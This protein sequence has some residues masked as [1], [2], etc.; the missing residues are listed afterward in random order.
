M[1]NKDEQE[2][3][4]STGGIGGLVQKVS[5]AVNNFNERL[6]RGEGNQIWQEVSDTLSSWKDKAQENREARENRT[7]VTEEQVQAFQDKVAD[8][9][10]NGYDTL[11][12]VR[13]D[14]QA[15]SDLIKE[16]VAKTGTLD[17]KSS[18]YEKFRDIAESAGENSPKEIKRKNKTFTR[19]NRAWADT[20]GT[21][22]SK[23]NAVDE[24]GT[25][26][27]KG[28][29]DESG[30]FVSGLAEWAEDNE[31]R[32]N[33]EI[34]A[35][36]DTIENSKFLTEDE[37][38]SRQQEL[39]N[40][41]YDCG[42]LEEYSQ[43]VIDDFKAEYDQKYFSSEEE[44]AAWD[45]E[46]ARLEN[47]QKV[48]S[49]WKDQAKGL[50]DKWSGVNEIYSYH[51]DDK[52][53]DA[54][55]FINDPAYF[56]SPEYGGDTVEN[57]NKKLAR[58][59][60]AIALEE[61]KDR[62][63][64]N[65][66]LTT[67]KDEYEQ[68]KKNIELAKEREK[69][70]KQ[71]IEDVNDDILIG[72]KYLFY[73]PE[74]LKE[75]E[76][77]LSVLQSNSSLSEAERTQVDK[78]LAYVQKHIESNQKQA[79]K[80]EW[81]GKTDTEIK[82]EI[83]RLIKGPETTTKPSIK[84]SGRSVEE[85]QAEIDKLE[86]QFGSLNPLKD[87]EKWDSIQDQIDVLTAEKATVSQKPAA[88]EEIPKYERTAEE[89]LKLQAL[90][91]ILED[92]ALD[93]VDNQKSEL[94]NVYDQ[95][96]KQYGESGA[97]V[98]MEE[99]SA[100]TREATAAYNA[101]IEE[102]VTPWKEAEAAY[103]MGE[104][105]AYPKG[106]KY[107][108]IRKELKAAG[109]GETDT[110]KALEYIRGKMVDLS[111]NSK[112]A[113]EYYKAVVASE[114]ATRIWD[115]TLKERSD[116]NTKV[117][118]GQEKLDAI[119]GVEGLRKLYQG[120]VD[121]LA[122]GL[123]I[124]KEDAK[125]LH[126]MLGTLGVDEGM[127]TPSTT[128]LDSNNSW[129][130]TLRNF[131]TSNIAGEDRPDVFS[132]DEYN[133]FLYLFSDDVIHSAEYALEKNSA[134]NAA[135]EA[136]LK[137]KALNV[138][139][140]DKEKHPGSFAFFAVIDPVA[141]AV[142]NMTGIV[143][144]VETRSQ[145]KNLGHDVA[146]GMPSLSEWASVINE[147]NTSIIGQGEYGFIKPD[148]VEF[149]YNAY[150]S[151]IQSR[152]N[153]AAVTKMAGGLGFVRNGSPV[154]F[155]KNAFELASGA[156]SDVAFFGSASMETYREL[157]E[158]GID[159][160]R[161][162]NVGT[163]A[164]VFEAAFEHISLDKIIHEKD[165]FHIKN[166]GEALGEVMVHNAVEG[167]EE[168]CTE[169]ANKVY[170][171]IVL[172]EDSTFWRN[173][174]KLR[175]EGLTKAEAIKKEYLNEA[176]EILLA[177]AAGFVSSVVPAS[178]STF[179]AYARSRNDIKDT[180]KI[181]G[182]EINKSASNSEGETLAQRLGTFL[183]NYEFYTAE[184]VTPNQAQKK[185]IN[186]LKEI[187]TKAAE[188]KA[189]DTEIAQMIVLA[190][191]YD[192]KLY[193]D[194]VMD[195]MD[196]FLAISPGS[197]G[198]AVIN[199]LS[200]I[201]GEE[202]ASNFL[203]AFYA[204]PDAYVEDEFKQGLR[205]ALG[206]SE[207]TPE[208]AEQV[209]ALIGYI[210]TGNSTYD[211]ETLRK[212]IQTIVKDDKT[213]NYILQF[214]GNQISKYSQGNKRVFEFQKENDPSATA[215]FAAVTDRSAITGDFE[216]SLINVW[217]GVKEAVGYAAIH[218][219]ARES[220]KETLA[221]FL[222]SLGSVSKTQMAK[223][224]DDGDFFVAKGPDGK[225][226]IFT[227]EFFIQQHKKGVDPLTGKPSAFQNLVD[228]D[229]KLNA[230]FDG[231]LR[232]TIG[233]GG[234]ADMARY[235]LRTGEEKTAEQTKMLKDQLQDI[236][237]VPDANLAILRNEIRDIDRQ[238]SDLYTQAE[239][240]KASNEPLPDQHEDA[241]K[242]LEARKAK[243]EADLKIIQER[244]KVRS[245]GRI[246]T[247]DSG[248]SGRNA[249]AN[250]RGNAGG[251]P[252]RTGSTGQSSGTV[253]A[254]VGRDPGSGSGS[255]LR[256]EV[257][258]KDGDT[259][260]A[261]MDNGSV[262]YDS[263]DPKANKDNLTTAEQDVLQMAKDAGVDRLI[264]VDADQ[265]YG[266]GN[267]AAGYYVIIGGK[268]TI[269]VNSNRG[270]VNGYHE[271]MH[272]CLDSYTKEEKRAILDQFIVGL[273]GSKEEFKSFIN[274]Y[275]NETHQKVYASLYTAFK[276]GN[277]APY[278]YALYEEILCDLWKGLNRYHISNEQFSPLQQRAYAFVVENQIIEHA[279]DQ[280]KQ[281]KSTKKE[282]PKKAPETHGGI[283]R[284]ETPK[285]QEAPKARSADEQKAEEFF[286][287]LV[288]QSDDFDL[289]PF[290]SAA[291]DDLLQYISGLDRAG[292]AEKQVIAAVKREVERRQGEDQRVEEEKNRPLDTSFGEARLAQV[293]ETV[294][295]LS[296]SELAGMMREMA[297]LLGRISK[298][299]PD[300]IILEPVTNILINEYRHRLAQRGSESSETE[301]GTVTSDQPTDDLPK[302]K[303]KSRSKKTQQSATQSTEQP[304][305]TEEQPVAEQPPESTGNPV[306]D[307]INSLT[308][309]IAEYD[310]MIAENTADRDKQMK[311]AADP[312]MRAIIKGEANKLI[313]LLKDERA[314]LQKRL[315]ALKK[316]LR[317]ETAKN[318]KDK[319]RTEL[320]NN[321]EKGS[322]KTP[323]PQ[324]ETH[325]DN[326]TQASVGK[327]N[328]NAFQYDNPEVK[329]FFKRAAD[330]LMRDLIYMQSSRRTEYGKGTVYGSTNR[331]LEKV[332]E[333]FGSVDKAI[334][335][336]EAIIT[337]RG[338]ENYAG[339]K[340]IEL[341]L[342]EMLSDGYTAIS[343]E[344]ESIESSAEYMTL[345]GTLQGGTPFDARQRAIEL[346]LA[347]DFE[348]ELTEED[349]GKIVDANKERTGYYDP[350]TRDGQAEQETAGVEDTEEELQ[351]AIDKNRDEWISLMA[352]TTNGSRYHHYSDGWYDGYT[353]E[354]VEEETVRA[355]EQR[356]QELESQYE[357]LA[358]RM[359]RIVSSDD[360]DTIY[361]PDNGQPITRR[362][363]VDRAMQGLDPFDGVVPAPV[364]TR[365]EANEEF[366]TWIREQ[367]EATESGLY[368][369]DDSYTPETSDIYNKFSVESLANGTGFETLYQITGSNK[370]TTLEDWIT[371]NQRE[372][373]E[374]TRDSLQNDFSQLVE[375]GAA[376]VIGVARRDPNGELLKVELDEITSGAMK[377]SPL[378]QM[379]TYAKEF[380]RISEEEANRQYGFLADLVKLLY[381]YDDTDFVWRVV[382]SEMFAA[383][384]NNSDPQYGKTI[385]F[386][387]I[388]KKTQATIDAIS[389]TMKLLGTGLSKEEI[390]FV[391]KMVG[392]AGESTPCPVCYVFSR[393]MGL[394]SVLDNIKRYQD[395]YGDRNPN[396]QEEALK[397]VREVQDRALS[398]TKG[399]S[400]GKAVNAAQAD[401]LKKLKAA[402][403]NFQNYPLAQLGSKDKK[404]NRSLTDEN[405]KAVTQ[406]YWADQISTLAADY[407][408]FDAYKWAIKTRLINAELLVKNSEDIAAKLRK[409]Y[410][411]KGDTVEA[412]LDNALQ[413]TNTTDAF[414]DLVNELSDNIADLSLVEPERLN[415]LKRKYALKKSQS[416][417][418]G[419][420]TKLT[421]SGQ[422]TTEAQRR[423]EENVAEYKEL[424]E[425]LGTDDYVFRKGYKDVPDDILFDLNKGEQFARYY[426]ETWTYRTT[427]GSGLGKAIMPYSDARVGEI[428]QGVALGDV[429]GVKIGKDQNAFL[430][431]LDPRKKNEA[432]KILATARK[433][434]AAQ[435]LIGGMRF[436]STSDFRYEYASD[437]LMAFFE[438]QAMGANVQLY[439]KVLEAVDFFANV[440][441][442]VNLSVMPR[443]KGIGV[444][445][446][447]PRDW[448][449]NYDRYYALEDG[450]YV[451]LRKGKSVPDFEPG[452]YHAIL[453]SDVTGVNGGAA[454]EYVQKY[455]NVQ[456]IMVGISADH[457]NACL[458]SDDITFI[459][460]FHGSGN[461]TAD[462]QQLMQLLGETI[463][464]KNITD[465]TDYQ[466]DAQRETKNDARDLRH[467]IVSG[468]LLTTDGQIILTAEEANILESHELLRDL[469][470]RFYLDAT[471]KNG[472]ID[473]GLSKENREKVSVI[474]TNS[475]GSHVKLDTPDFG[476]VNDKAFAKKYYLDGR[477]ECYGN[478]L[479]GAAA[480]QI[481]PYEYWD[482]SLK[483][484]EAKGNGDAFQAYAKSLGLVPRFSGFAK[485]KDYKAELDFTKNDNY[486]KL[487]ID[488][489][490]Y[491]N[492]GNYR[493]QR[494]INL[495]EVDVGGSDRFDFTTLNPVY[496]EVN[497]GSG[498]EFANRVNPKAAG[499]DNSVISKINDPRKT[500]ALA[501]I[502]A[503]AIRETRALSDKNY[504]HMFSNNEDIQQAMENEDYLTAARMLRENPTAVFNEQ[505]GELEVIAEDPT[506]ETFLD[507]Y[508]TDGKLSVD[509][510]DPD[511][512]AWLNKLYED[513]DVVFTYK[514]YLEYKDEDGVYLIAPMAG[515]QKDEKGNN[516][517]SHKLRPMQWEKSI[518]NPNSKN[519]KK[520]KKG[521]WVYV[522]EK[523]DVKS[524]VDATYNPYQ[525]SGDLAINDQFAIAY[526]RP[527]L[528]TYI[529]A[530]PKS[531]LTSGYH[532]GVTDPEAAKRSDGEIVTAKDPVGVLDWKT[533]PF[534]SQLQNSKRHTYLSRWLMPIQRVSDEEVARQ[535]KEIIDREPAGLGVPFNVVPQNVRNILEDMG[536]PIDITG[537]GIREDLYRTYLRD[538]NEQRRQEG[539]EPYPYS[540]IERT[541]QEKE[542]IK[543]QRKAEAKRMREERGEEWA[544]YKVGDINKAP[545]EKFSVD[546]ED[547]EGFGNWLNSYSSNETISHTA[548]ESSFASFPEL[549]FFKKMVDANW[550]NSGST[551]AVE[552]EFQEF[553]SKLDDYS[554]EKLFKSFAN[555]VEGSRVDW[556]RY[557]NTPD[558]T[559]DKFEKKLRSI[560]EKDL[561]KKGYSSL[562]KEQLDEYRPDYVAA[563]QQMYDKDDKGN[564]IGDDPWHK[565]HQALYDLFTKHPEL[566]YLKRLGYAA[567]TGEKNQIRAE[568]E[569]LL[570]GINDRDA[571]WQL[572][573]YSIYPSMG[574]WNGGSRV[575]G[576]YEKLKK[577]KRLFSNIIEK[578]RDQ[579]LVEAG[580]S[581]NVK[582]EARDYTLQEVIDMF[583]QLNRDEQL[584]PLAEKVFKVTKDLGL[585]IRGAQ[586]KA[587]RTS[588]VGGHQLGSVVEYNINR[589]ND[590]GITDQVKATILLHELIHGCT[591]YALRDY[592]GDF[593]NLQLTE[594]M[595]EAVRQIMKVYYAVRADSNL[596][597]MYG[598][599]S[600]AEMLSELANP[601]FREALEKK[602]LVQRII[603][604]IK[605]FFGIDTKNVLDAA[606]VGL[607]YLLDNFNYD[608]YLDWVKYS[609]RYIDRN[610]EVTQR[611]KDSV[612]A[613]QQSLHPG[614]V[615]LS[616][617]HWVSQEYA[618]QD[619]YGDWQLKS[620]YILQTEN[621]VAQV[622]EYNPITGEVT[623]A[624]S[625]DNDSQQSGFMTGAIDDNSNYT[626]EGFFNSLGEEVTVGKFSADDRILSVTYFAGAGT[627]DYALRD[628]LFHLYAVEYD[629][630]IRDMFLK[631][632]GNAIMVT[633]ADVNE[634]VPG[635][636]I[637][638]HV[639]YFHASPVCTNFSIANNK[640]GETERDRQFARS[641]AK[642]I[643][644]Y[645]PD[646]FTL[647]NVKGYVGS[648]SLQIVLDTLD[649][650][651]YTHDG[652][653]GNI[654]RASDYG[655]ATIRDRL[656]VRAVRNGDLPPK[657]IEVGP[658]TWWA[659]VEDIINTL[660]VMDESGLTESRRNRLRNMGID[661]N[662]L[663]Q[664]LLLLS[665]T[666]GKEIQYAYADQ[667]SPTLMTD[668]SEARIILTDG[669]ILK[670]TPRVFARIQG[671]DDEF[672]FPT[673]KRNPEKIHQTNAFKI[674]GNGIPTQLTRAIVNPLLDTIE[675]KNKQK[676][677]DQYLGAIERGDMDTARALFNR[678]VLGRN[679]GAVTPFL[680]TSKY[681]DN[682]GH[683]SAVAHGIKLKNAKYLNMAADE[684]VSQV[685]DDAVLIP[686]P[687]RHGY[688]SDTLE[689]AQAI[690]DRY[691]ETHETQIEVLDILKGNDRPSQYETKRATGKSLNLDTFGM[692]LDG[693]IP[694]GKFPVLIDNVVA[695]GTTATSA[696]KAVGGGMTLAFAYGDRSKPV[697]GLKLADPVTY[698]DN[699]NPIPLSERFNPDNPDIR[700]STD[701]EPEM[702]LNFRDP[703]GELLERVF[704]GEKIYETRPYTDKRG[705]GQIKSAW[706]NK[707]MGI[708]QTGAGRAKVVGQWELGDGELRDSQ[709]LLDHARELGNDGTEFEAHPGE[710]KWIYPIK[711]AE[712]VEPRD[713][714]SWGPQARSIK[715]SVDIDPA[716]VFDSFGYE[717]ELD[718]YSPV[719]TLSDL[720][721]NL[722]Y[723]SDGNTA[724][725][726]TETGETVV[727]Q[728][729]GED[730]PE[731][732][733]INNLE[734]TN[735]A[736][737]NNATAEPYIIPPANRY[738]NDG[739]NLDQPNAGLRRGTQEVLT[740]NQEGT[741]RS[742]RS[743][744]ELYAESVPQSEET[745]GIRY[746][747]E[748]ESPGA[749]YS[750]M[751]D[752]DSDTFVN[753]NGETVATDDMYPIGSFT[754]EIFKALKSGDQSLKN[755]EDLINKLLDRRFN[756]YE[757]D[758]NT[759]QR[760]IQINDA[761]TPEQR[762]AMLKAMEKLVKKHGKMRSAKEDM[763]QDLHFAV[764]R[765]Q[766]DTIDDPNHKGKKITRKEFVK[767]A[768]EGKDPFTGEDS[769]KT[770]TEKEA[771]KLFD[772]QGTVIMKFTQTV[773]RNSDKEWLTDEAVRMALTDE[774][775]SYTPMANDEAIRRAQ[776]R[777]DRA[778]SYE[779]ALAEWDGIVHSERTPK[780][781]DVAF[782]ELLL[783][784]ATE[785]GL[786][787]DTVKLVSDLTL[788][789]HTTGQTLQAFRILKKMTPRGQLYY[790]QSVV[791]D[792][793][794]R[795]DSRIKSGKMGTVTLN[796]SLVELLLSSSTREELDTAVDLIKKDLA[797][798][799]PAT[800][801]DQWN[802]W[803][804]LAMLGNPRTHFRNIF[805]NGAFMPAVFVKDMIARG[806]EKKY[807]DP[808]LRMRI[809]GA[810]L[811]QNS[812][813]RQRAEQ[814]FQVMRKIIA[815]EAGG[816]KYSDIQ[817][818]L[819]QRDVFPF[820]W[821]NDL[822]RFNGG[823][824]SA[825]DLWFMHKYY[826]RAFAE[827]LQA[828]GIKE[829]D[830]QSFDSN[831]DGRKTLNEIRNWAMEEAQRNTYHDANKLA[832][833][834]NQM[835]RSSPTAYVVLEGLVPFTKTPAN[836]LKRGIE[837]SPIGL[838]SSYIQLG[839]DL[840]SGDYSTSQCI[841]RLA[842]GWT[843]TMLMVAGFILSKMGVLRGGGPDDK[844]E[845]AF[846]TLQGHQPW[847][848]EIGGFSYTLDW[849]APTALP[850]FV[851]NAIYSML[852]GDHVDITD[853]D[854]WMALA[855]I[856]DPLLSLSMLDGIENTL[857]AVSNANN[858]SKL[859]VLGISMFGSYLAQGM[860][861]ILGQAA[862]I[863]D[864]NRRKTFVPEGAKSS[865]LKQWVQ[866]S[867]QAK[868]P[869]P[870]GL[871]G[872]NIP[873]TEDDKK[874]YV[875]M[876]GRT[877]GADTFGEVLWKIAENVISPGYHKWINETPV[878]AELQRLYEATQDKS[879]LPSYVDKSIGPQSQGK[880]D[881]GNEIIIDGKKL[882]ADEMT[883]YEMTVGQNRYQLLSDIFASQAYQ[884]ATDTE[885]K[886][887]VSDA[888]AYAKSLGEKAVIDGREHDY[889]W[890][891]LADKI[892]ASDYILI[893]QE[894][895]NNKSN[896][897]IFSWLVNNPNLNENQVAT[898][899][900]DKFN[901]PDNVE[902]VSSSGF[903]YEL[904]GS[905]EDIIK[906]INAQII[907]DGLRKLYSSEEYQNAPDKDM[908]L[909]QF[910]EESRAETIKLYGEM[911]DQTDRV[912]YVGK[913]ASIGAESFNKVLDLTTADVKG[914]Y[915]SD[916]EAQ[917]SWLGYKYK[918]DTSIN[919]PL[920]EGYSIELDKTQRS[921][922]ESRFRDRWNDAYDELVHSEK[923]QNAPSREYQE[924]MIA[925]RFN[926]VSTEVENEYAAELYQAGGYSETFG[927]PGSFAWSK[928]YEIAD[929]EL[930]TPQEQAE[931]LAGKYS[932]GSSIDDP[933]QAAYEINLTTEDKN[934]LKKEFTSAYVP[935]YVKMVNSAEFK[936][937]DPT[938]QE[939]KK[940]E[941]RKDV[942]K[943]VQEAYAR[944]L[945]ADGYASVAYDDKA[946]LANKYE[947][948][949]SND[950]SNKE[951]IE[952]IKDSYVG[953]TIANAE[954]RGYRKQL[955]D[956]WMDNPANT[957][958]YLEQNTADS[959]KKMRDAADKY[960]GKLTKQKYGNVKNYSDIEDFDLYDVYYTTNNP[961]NGTPPVK[962]NEPT[963]SKTDSGALLR[964]GN[965]DLNARPI[966]RNSDGSYSTVD[967]ATWEVD[968]KYVNVPTVIYVED[969]TIDGEYISGDW[970][971]VD[972]DKALEHYFETGEHLGIYSDEKSAVRAAE[973]LHEDQAK[974]YDPIANF[975]SNLIRH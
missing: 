565:S 486:W 543:K 727:I 578:R 534:G 541:D 294:S 303:K 126:K 538:V 200:A 885:K 72:R 899:I 429:K 963:T 459:I 398:Y 905:D 856:A 697:P 431:L 189:S 348:Q 54:D 663:K 378:G 116:Y 966:V 63:G 959:Y 56:A 204:N 391:Y 41:Y 480:N 61:E 242:N 313:Q 298:D 277:T 572:S 738:G 408:K 498:S 401:I 94:K 835:K 592:D 451:K 681:S 36:N 838:V 12:A 798:Q 169:T 616:T 175:E 496:G 577:A 891:N 564:L 81:S 139:Q 40:L 433:K 3:S 432:E 930:S 88:P 922:L 187:A 908:M 331:F 953:G 338:G 405:G 923:F 281:S 60:K 509:V 532:Y 944:K 184:G 165:V 875:D 554:K 30:N 26:H 560:L 213:K 580:D 815:G 343:P 603:D 49:G 65:S 180:V 422:D 749:R 367:Y 158:R 492:Q 269:V 369:V 22:G 136:R 799:I 912:K 846:E 217:S 929:R 74:K 164:G 264:F 950:L 47:N 694:E 105:Y 611:A 701:T 207:Y 79:I 501:Q 23:R 850:L 376:R 150:S 575:S 753:E 527:N 871:F 935:R 972:A 847:S 236:L 733:Y 913:A 845:E 717:V 948:L 248:T 246:Q 482:K 960:A 606:S 268:K 145:I 761:Y 490:M 113:Q 463:D 314:E 814:D 596:T 542:A 900:A 924:D 720:S 153:A 350:D 234:L 895:E 144:Y 423:V 134:K 284:A 196:A 709:W 434:M 502:S 834:L 884:E 516:Q 372:N 382:G 368:S 357:D 245:N 621:G 250:E 675:A 831:P 31:A 706:L 651:G 601:D 729:I 417:L 301:E 910:Y 397:L 45:A 337:D 310:R 747:A 1:P 227:R 852:K 748:E 643:R 360:S 266:N 285:V 255:T 499:K 426:P 832:S 462:I 109:I 493:A 112:E 943:S 394:G 390:K 862:R 151:M 212:T 561:D 450:R 579:I 682:Y 632:N 730:S 918:A 680:Y 559:L 424:I 546:E 185:E 866:S 769:D 712:R 645:T 190:N 15:V 178:A 775:M 50:Y 586:G 98:W 540:F 231:Q 305:T 103:L 915:R 562:T 547:V 128:E 783:K 473:V 253:Q 181:L 604:A 881:D 623:P 566:D 467:K 879:V 334:E 926:Q 448:D 120:G 354:K 415:K 810:D 356:L 38:Q 742:G 328:V 102:N 793:N 474:R 97:Q 750:T 299:N 598:A 160:A 622:Y 811:S 861:T 156:F 92:R 29:T 191:R 238:L 384:K 771:N 518:G 782:G 933:D 75:E 898:L 77:R 457:I 568:F 321:I 896:E 124:S 928:A 967:T 785:Q 308:Q 889:E 504:G 377:N 648:D 791:D 809:A 528:V 537:T 162:W 389:K 805:G 406:D 300:R 639:P 211:E 419:V 172:G 752:S 143:D 131:V 797:E 497:F 723:S 249:D 902:S 828:R 667:P 260:V 642:A 839:R 404:I 345:K 347:G 64:T 5:D 71:Q 425:A 365:E 931:W 154:I 973:Q 353:G 841:D 957:A 533:G 883:K 674:V 106:G 177:G 888:Y 9:R 267:R 351:A 964:P 252:Y 746:S 222:K 909:K 548:F 20:E 927:K 687:G 278:Y 192:T 202:D 364:M 251:I 836:I 149:C 732:R 226:H 82:A 696:Q 819:G 947:Y 476:K 265:L 11:E 230:E 673:Q 399:R 383:I 654:Y 860:P 940:E 676:I 127:F 665:G 465:F 585:T 19:N 99:S 529:C 442:D 6:E 865:A 324:P 517:L 140:Y 630:D 224:R 55:T 869:D 336:C 318:N 188:G 176:K 119:G 618:E 906:E 744:G 355:F 392:E 420:V 882:T 290:V 416:G 13:V 519:I 453:Y 510:T 721:N 428:V 27:W 221:N 774:S 859:G 329:P 678:Y 93:S 80:E 325:I 872:G 297:D 759:V 155:D 179:S 458:D 874:L 259:A 393:W 218:K 91:S 141:T 767:R 768:T 513:G 664:P 864:T 624:G 968:G 73:S 304:T 893:R 215:W 920:H 703:T 691:N 186:T 400:F 512:L 787:N 78:D 901:P 240:A 316:Q 468:K 195:N 198:K 955:F 375:S 807:V 111:T 679:I 868:I 907:Q 478:F 655:A 521:N 439:T 293:R 936:A 237:S 117:A 233:A 858:T 620:G 201:Y 115:S 672:Q 323:N 853:A 817:D 650:M 479:S 702:G 956:Q 8:Y 641:I 937:L 327:S 387:T 130:N 595:R 904:N 495:S 107:D 210:V 359:S 326:R 166:F 549:D 755:V 610:P 886:K 352:T 522:L 511:E 827:A 806:L 590:L 563:I 822:A 121:K 636:I 821:L 247:H 719:V 556:S 288:R 276:N 87:T 671:L 658:T 24:N 715:F 794:K 342:D 503:N 877:E 870:L 593:R 878:D 67:Y 280:A 740:Q 89:E 666:K 970:V 754:R 971:H 37:V 312:N 225:D 567:T 272:Y 262:V 758:Y 335:A 86:K 370:T 83:D 309:E 688:A 346:V 818:I 880:D 609:N 558:K 491:D 829:E 402:E 662:N 472:R 766:G 692:Y 412:V 633:D 373:E 718:D 921:R 456:M 279:A 974:Q 229:D 551:R 699:G 840:R 292:D 848:I 589:F 275:N 315:A 58:L 167:V 232:A 600:A 287:F 257:I 104:F 194:F 574:V 28:H 932:P 161:A 739:Y 711:W 57:L 803:R 483:Q 813:Y 722:Y 101:F 263:A 594:D 614:E 469:F 464:R 919:N 599:K 612:S 530:I 736:N 581:S 652:Y 183:G 857:S 668:G 781:V 34:N 17:S 941:L 514:S 206:D 619:S 135:F 291:P 713:V 646:V 954:A 778:G 649:D 488:R 133:N 436:Q 557:Y 494:Q 142:M 873:G 863:L 820:K 544:N 125:E 62:W 734:A 640:H 95:Y 59:D 68:T 949:A 273:F 705:N 108:E 152:I 344:T 193:N 942:A 582:L 289:D 588:K 452:K 148:V 485:G 631:N 258:L 934:Q 524:P 385:D 710:S 174:T 363:F 489:K 216:D 118:Q 962:I 157:R 322:K 608:A 677:D 427:R 506:Q 470:R 46:L 447:K 626:I 844:K 890:M 536:V 271:A 296:D 693:Q 52:L 182:S 484:S 114:T 460:P 569:Q 945:K 760:M 449:T 413:S 51:D 946:N 638:G 851:G 830:V 283:P 349:A 10:Q 475:D 381:S 395:M 823:R 894:Y 270:S 570:S 756:I 197:V 961:I 796:Q 685:P 925:R 163:A 205:A 317:K 306:Q 208:Y 535:Y 786:I 726:Q 656:F 591:Q 777:F 657:P 802:A 887:I 625:K 444:L 523:S 743:D 555:Y 138:T 669:T 825:E 261:S 396:G 695:S 661:I 7:P 653:E 917:S 975:W 958:P 670:V 32:I 784:S 684:M 454:K 199:T 704:N 741:L 812:A 371:A 952:I 635:T 33:S 302:P 708:I 700:Y 319:R 951:K 435:N 339:P 35:Y 969:E 707:P 500:D 235:N 689:L 43:K 487:L 757:E 605:K 965:I 430:D 341:F 842:A 69:D 100:K 18:I 531:E 833:L 615:K 4:T 602:N 411:I 515:L 477:N 716:A 330:V 132:T 939:Y 307:E 745:Q 505:T 446:E 552:N 613:Y 520:N 203:N 170:E 159:P 508:E 826:T 244:A 471:D 725:Y 728:D 795:Y 647:E 39:A 122:S 911:L 804:Y 583:N 571:L 461:S 837:Y 440:G 110:S 808:K 597:N 76:A 770:M 295:N 254:D 867:I 441:C 763:N 129:K 553:I 386:S 801:M 137:E 333:N 714:T 843:G 780:Q 731:A 445:N 539:K 788:M 146:S 576:E 14:K 892:G 587:F 573:V 916:I 686:M 173:V 320:E 776:Q 690:A 466:I 220:T 70:L 855:R 772:K 683:N 388:C 90:E 854:T 789:A 214:L 147:V 526:R 800:W 751:Y 779:K 282:E 737:T 256:Q 66:T 607:D 407:D 2:K 724:Y 762:Q 85:I 816:N 219:Q 21:T 48:Y 410:K 660:P 897:K 634:V 545:T 84:P 25:Y 628:R 443:D 455:D 209:E 286:D 241:I 358:E 764:Q 366:N 243:A 332:T 790:I 437:Y 765:D 123:G 380:G 421:K 379:V 617:G 16:E 361:S 44:K 914:D 403:E 550:A 223:Y 627:L 418:K 374:L 362:E 824:L 735:N 239:M 409:T 53:W 507:D 876:W 903:L 274:L 773:A 698:D 168:I 525:H 849:M 644:E 311:E 171:R 228:T 792:L 938:T 340:R 584:N 42:D 629:P 438:M 637:A 96:M 481:F 414:T 659:A